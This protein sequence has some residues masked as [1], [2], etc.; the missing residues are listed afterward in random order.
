M[1]WKGD[2]L[3]LDAALPVGLRSA[4]LIFSAVADALQWI[5]ESMEVQWVVHYIDDFVTL[6]VPDSTECEENI[7]IKR[8][9]CDRVGLP[10]EHEKDEGPATTI[11]FVGIELDSVA[12]EIRL[13]QETLKRLKEELSAW[14]SRKACKKRELLSLIG[15][16]SHACKAVRA[17]RSFLHRLID[18]SMVPQHLDHYVRLN[19]D[20]R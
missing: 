2:I 13:P 11:S 3:Y 5:M 12:K 10:I 20:A 1:K 18:L 14:R 9:A 17:G 4:P 7:S 16:L 15:L 8:N 6:G 19:L